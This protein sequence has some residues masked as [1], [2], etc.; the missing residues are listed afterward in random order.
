MEPKSLYQAVQALECLTGLAVSC[1]DAKFRVVLPRKPSDAPTEP[2]WHKPCFCEQLHAACPPSRQVCQSSDLNAFHAAQ[3]TRSVCAYSC[4]FGLLEAVAP[5]S[6]GDQIIG[7]L[8]MGKA[9][10][11]QADAK[12]HTLASMTEL[13]SERPDPI[14]LSEDLDRLPKLTAAQWAA[15]QD[16]LQIFASYI[17][18]NH[19]LVLRPGS[20]GQLTREYIRQHYR[21]KLTLDELSLQLHCSTVTLNKHFRHEFGTTVFQYINDKRMRHAEQ[22][23]TS[24]DLPISEV[25]ESSGFSDANYFFRLFKARH[26]VS[27]T[28]YRKNSRTGSDSTDDQA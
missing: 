21:D 18:T 6:H 28:A 14:G 11:A 8:M 9:L 7:Y 5:I 23:L 27:P 15:Y 24:S 3:E 16:T 25:A 17:E 4:P 20:L 13:L 2:Q 12:A 1:Y 10:P 22:L 26:G 19:L